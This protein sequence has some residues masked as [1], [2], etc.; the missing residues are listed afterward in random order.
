MRKVKLKSKNKLK[1]LVKDGRVRI[2]HASD[3]GEWTTYGVVDGA[4]THILN[5]YFENYGQDY[6][7]TKLDN[8]VSERE[9]EVIGILFE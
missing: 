7:V 4:F 2:I 3:S 1:E 6:Q 8:S 5:V 9:L